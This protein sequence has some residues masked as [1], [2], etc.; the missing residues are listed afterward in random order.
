MGGHTATAETRGSKSQV[1]DLWLVASTLGAPRS[2]G[3]LRGTLISRKPKPLGRLPCSGCY[4]IRASELQQRTVNS[5][6]SPYT[7]WLR[8]QW[9]DVGIP[10]PPSSGPVFLRLPTR[11]KLTKFFTTSLSLPG[12]KLP[13]Y[14][15]RNRPIRFCQEERAVRKSDL[16]APSNTQRQH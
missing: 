14:N 6:L 11:Q 2:S 12:E 5:F 15:N 4:P 16:V 9:K 13:R 10:E 8:K 1:L 3:C 7:L